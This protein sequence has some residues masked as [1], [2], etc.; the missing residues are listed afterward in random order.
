MEEANSTEGYFEINN[1]VYS[2][3][4]SQNLTKL[5][6]ETGSCEPV[7]FFIKEKGVN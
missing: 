5:K 7:F 1:F 4:V 2:S 3:G 6:I